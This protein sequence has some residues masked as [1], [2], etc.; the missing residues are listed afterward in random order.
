M[1]SAQLT[2]DINQAVTRSLC[3]DL[4]V[5]TLNDITSSADITA[6]LIPANEQSVAT[7]IT[8]EDCVICGVEWVNQVFE[9]LDNV[10][11]DSAAQNTE[12]IW[13]VN[14]GQTV[15]ANTTL[16]ELKGN[17]RIL[18][19]GERTALNF[20]QSLSATSTVTAKY[21]ERL[22]GTKTKLLDTRKTIPGLRLAQKY[23]VTCGGGV[24]HR[25]GLFDAFLIKE[26]HIAACGGITKA[27]STARQNHPS[28]TVEV[29]V[30][31]IE[32]LTEALTAQADIIMLDNFTPEMIEQAVTLT[33]KISAGKTKLEVS[34]NMTFDTLTTYA[35]SGVDFISVGAITKHVNAIDLSMRFV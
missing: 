34:G 27:I 12:I 33:Q 8:R 18:L 4:G 20:L 17:A 24:N 9:Q 28:K 29:E 21:V 14:D 2:T 10:L 30:E 11:A 3:E 19:T 15:K 31:G 23:A 6:E 13:F 32:E 22:S 26:N 7:V 1:F 25:I 35:K 16:F 5:N